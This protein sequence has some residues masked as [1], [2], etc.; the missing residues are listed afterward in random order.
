MSR[1]SVDGRIVS[2]NVADTKG[3]RKQPVE[4]ITLVVDHGVEGDA[5]AGPWHR[6]VSL[7]AIESIEKMLAAC[8]DV[9]P[10]DF[11]EN[12]TTEGLVL[13]DCRSARASAPARRWSR[14]PRSARSATTAARSSIRRATA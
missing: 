2:V 5:H 10:G 9:S 12:M 11:G 7:L 1:H 3:V 14:S 4:S 6:Q 8:P 13:Y